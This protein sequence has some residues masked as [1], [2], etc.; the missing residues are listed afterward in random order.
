MLVNTADNVCEACLRFNPKFQ[1]IFF[2]KLESR[3]QVSFMSHSE[4]PD[5]CGILMPPFGSSLLPKYVSRDAALLFQTLREPGRIPHLIKNIFGANAEV[6]VRQLILDSI[7]EIEHE[8]RFLTGASALPHISDVVIVD[9]THIANI[10]Y[11]AIRYGL[12]LSNLSVQELAARLYMFNRIPCT[13][14][15][16]LQFAKVEQVIEF[17]VPDTEVANQLKSNW[18]GNVSRRVWY[19][20][21]T[22]VIS[23][24]LNFKLYISPILKDLPKIFRLTVDAL[25]KT[26]CSCFKVGLGAFGLLRPDKLVAYFADLED[27]QQAANLIR[28]SATG[29]SVQGVPFTGLIDFEGL[30]SWGIDPPNLRGRHSLQSSQSWRQWVTNRIAIYI[31]Y[32]KEI[33]AE[34][35]MDFVLRRIELDNI[36]PVTWSPS[37]TVWRNFNQFMEKAS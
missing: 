12:E 8:E 26:K 28:A 27:L 2:D 31:L 11:D 13:P 37:S 4:D 32:A 23:S 18:A 20:W 9:D 17:L 33:N 19:E 25:A 10:T 1:L 36:D 16:Q 24:P 30:V 22:S 5:F 14:L 35:P 34:N 7:L 15:L 3:K 21:R 6:Y 29:I